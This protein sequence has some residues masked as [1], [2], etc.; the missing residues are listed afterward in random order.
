MHSKETSYETKGNL[1]NLIQVIAHTN[2]AEN[3]PNCTTPQ[4]HNPDQLPQF[5]ALWQSS[6]LKLEFKC[7]MIYGK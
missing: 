1:R 2:F 5:M 3:L 4:N 7:T 6:S